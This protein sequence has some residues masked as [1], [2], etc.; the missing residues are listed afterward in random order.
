MILDRRRLLNP[1]YSNIDNVIGV[2]VISEGGRTEPEHGV[3]EL[4]ATREKRTARYISRYPI[5]RDRLIGERWE[6]RGW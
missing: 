3:A 6:S 1:R 4:L 5:I 2:E